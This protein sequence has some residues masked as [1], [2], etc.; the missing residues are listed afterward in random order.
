[1]S[2]RRLE[3]FCNV[4]VGILVQNIL[5]SAF[6]NWINVKYDNCILDIILG[7]VS[8]IHCDSWVSVSVACSSESVFVDVQGDGNIRYFEVVDN[9]PYVYFLSQYTS[10]KPQRGLGNNVCLCDCRT[11]TV[12]IGKIHSNLLWLILWDQIHWNRFAFLNLIDILFIWHSWQLQ[13][14]SEYHISHKYNLWKYKTQILSKLTTY[15][16][17]YKLTILHLLH[18]I[19]K[20]IAKLWALQLKWTELQFR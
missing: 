18:R 6:V 13:L 1:M 12:V 4:P 3:W 16:R 8:W 5:L 19:N 9:A 2:A 7:Y 14:V 10:D 15:T 17:S 11:H 20:G